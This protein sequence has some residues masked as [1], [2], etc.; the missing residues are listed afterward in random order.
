MNLYGAPHLE[1]EIRG[2][3]RPVVLLHG[4]T[5]VGSQ[6][7]HGSRRL[8]RSGH[9]TVSYDARSH[10][11]S[12]PPPPEIPAED[13]YS[14]EALAADLHRVVEESVDSESTFYLAGSSMGAHTAVRYALDRPERVAGLVLIGPAYSGQPIPP[15]ALEPWEQLS[16]GLRTGGSDGFVEAFSRTTQASG[17]W[18]DRLVTLA[19]DRISLHEHPHA[20]ADAIR[21]VPRSRPFSELDDLQAVQ[22]P[23]LVLGSSDQ[24]DPGHPAAVAREWAAALPDSRLVLD[25]PDQTPT[26][27]Q[28]GRLCDL[29]ADFTRETA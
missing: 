23:A 28:G 7:V 6:V 5:A 17:E 29:I 27:W 24:A 11:E 8:E 4:L 26:A 16:Q 22:I 9:Q 20:L 25:E 2:E 3:G 19:R 10:G 1:L 14:Y 21:W 12:D 13:A 15:A 18:K